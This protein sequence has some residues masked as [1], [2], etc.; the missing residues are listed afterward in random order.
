MT[1]ERLRSGQD[2]K[3]RFT[4]GNKLGRGRPPGA[5]NKTFRAGTRQLPEEETATEVTARRF[6]DLLAGIV[7]DLGGHEALSV[8]QLQLARRCAWISVQCEA[9]ERLSCLGER[10]IALERFSSLRF[11]ARQGKRHGEIEIRLAAWKRVRPQFV[12][13]NTNPRYVQ[14]YDLLFDGLRKAGL[15]EE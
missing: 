6:H 5:L 12:N 13:A 8:G 3:G 15:P 11:L 1:V 10:K 2:Q 14:Y 9:I 7:N 4:P